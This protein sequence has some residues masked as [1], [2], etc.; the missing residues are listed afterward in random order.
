[1]PAAEREFLLRAIAHPTSA[2]AR[3]A[4][5]AKCQEKNVPTTYHLRQQEK[6]QEKLRDMRDQVAAGKLVIRQMTPEER[7]RFPRRD[8]DETSARSKRR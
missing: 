6:H 5:N 3:A 4:L 1:M 8:V 2:G 7:K